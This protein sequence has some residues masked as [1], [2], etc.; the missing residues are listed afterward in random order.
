MMVTVSGPIS[1]HTGNSPSF[2]LATNSDVRQNS[3]APSPTK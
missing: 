2:A 3:T 1:T